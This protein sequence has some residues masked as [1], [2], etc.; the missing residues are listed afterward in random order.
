[1]PRSVG[2]RQ[3][4]VRILKLRQGRFGRY[5]VRTGGLRPSGLRVTVL[6]HPRFSLFPCQ[7]HRIELDMC[8]IL[9]IK[10]LIW[11]FHISHETDY[12]ACITTMYDMR[13]ANC[14]RSRLCAHNV[15]RANMLC[16]RMRA[17]VFWMA[18]NLS[19]HFS[20]HSCCMAALWSKL[21]EASASNDSRFMVTTFGLCEQEVCYHQKRNLSILASISI[22]LSGL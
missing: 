7:D 11:C 4:F 8:A 6:P 19:D 21:P 10:S 1:M 17:F 18:D 16:I 13:R 12:L 5:P 22:I 2:A 14:V 3:S 20:Y 15:T 9:T